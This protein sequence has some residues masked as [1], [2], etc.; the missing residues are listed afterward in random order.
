MGAVSPFGW[1]LDALAAGLF[2]G[3]AAIGDVDVFDTAP[4]RTSVAGQVPSGAGDSDPGSNT[5]PSPFLDEL[6]PKARA[7]LT[8]TDAFAV[9]AA[10]EAVRRAELDPGATSTGVFL[11]SST[12][13]MLEGEAFYRCLSASGEARDRLRAS[14]V[15]AQPNNAP[16]DAVA[17]TLGTRGPSLTLASACSA[18]SM[19]IEAALDSLREGECDAALA[20]GADGLCELTYAGFNSLRAVDA[21]PAQPFRKERGGMSLGEGA[22]VLVLETLEHARARGAPIL[23][24]LAGA[25]S[26]CDAHHMTAPDPSGDGLALAVRTALA[27]AERRPDEVGL[28]N[29]HGTGTPLNDAAEWQGLAQVFETRLR[30]LGFMATKG[31]V[32]HLLGACGGVEAIATVLALGRGEFPPTPGPSHELD[33]ACPARLAFDAPLRLEPGAGALSVNL[34]FGGANAALVFTPPPPASA[35]ST[36]TNPRSGERA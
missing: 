13:G 33:E 19:A 34:A 36:T 21:R 15:A 6:R 26:S 18:A 7:R 9:A 11:G 23:A 35:D 25:A 28:V 5:S 1:G 10:T 22:G 3:R 24:E 30:E 31:A 12:G 4:H 14:G 2:A 20:G 8:R 16:T 17:R 32:G 27:D 29:A